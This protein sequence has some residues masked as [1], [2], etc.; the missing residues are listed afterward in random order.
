[1]TTPPS[2]PPLPPADA[3]YAAQPAPFQPGAFPP[4]DAAIATW[5]LTKGFGDK[6]AVNGLSLVVRRGE[7]FGFLGPNGAGKSTTIKM[8]VG[9]LRPTTGAAF[10]GGVDVWREPLRAKELMGV[11]PEQLNLYERLSGRELIE[12]A[13]RLYDMP[14]D[15]VRRR[16]Q[17]LLNVLTLA[18]DADKL[19]VDY[20]VGMRK[21]VALAAALIHRPQVLFL[22]EPFE[23]IDPISSRVIR[24][25]LRDLTASGTTIFFSSHIMEVVERLCT[26]VG[27]IDG[28]TLIAE[29]TLADLRARAGSAGGDQSLEDI[30]L[31]LVGADKR[32]G[33]LE[34][35]E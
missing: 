28:G 18:D 21:K 11:L 15:E 4:P 9:L 12:F 5:G 3:A 29:G 13:G 17:S 24:D 2:F 10:I 14:K 27:I 22:D 7:F 31:H 35:L 34:W 23:G 19:V 33:G 26:R 8:M 25:I 32:E 1:M 30:F 16:A 6:I 20:S